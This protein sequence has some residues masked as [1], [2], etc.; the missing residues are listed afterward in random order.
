MRRLRQSDW[1]RRMVREN[2]LTPND[3]IWP[4]FVAGGQYLEEPISSM[5][6][7]NR[8]SID[9]VGLAA[10]EAANLGIPCIASTS[11]S[12]DPPAGRTA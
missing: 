2:H 1:S 5:P 9:M 10:K 3:L 8:L 4:I 6:G 11:P 12:G 7:V